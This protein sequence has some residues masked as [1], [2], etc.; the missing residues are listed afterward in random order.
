MN[1]RLD[2]GSVKG[3][4]RSIKCSS[5][6][7][8]LRSPFIGRSVLPRVRL[9]A[10]PSVASWVHT[11]VCSLVCLSVCS[12]VYSSVGPSVDQVG[13]SG[14][15][16]STVVSLLERFYDPQEGAVMLD[17]VDVRVRGRST[18]ASI[19]LCI[20]S[21]SVSLFCVL[22]V[23]L[24]ISIPASVSVYMRASAFYV[25]YQVSIYLVLRI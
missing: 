12:S 13:A 7:Y 14:A 15:G 19:C 21:P 8:P 3:V 24:P 23:S 6:D 17:G 11:F 5:V 1:A 4:H 9:F 25:Q 18:S 20:C 10:P 16:K 2:E 22:S